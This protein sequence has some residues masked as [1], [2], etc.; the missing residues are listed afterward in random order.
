MASFTN[1]WAKNIL[2]EECS[3][4]RFESFCCALFSEVDKCSYVTTSWNYDQGR[5]GRGAELSKGDSVLCVSLRTDPLKKA[6]EDAAKLAAKPFPPKNIRVCI[7]QENSKDATEA[8]LSKIKQI[9]TETVSAADNIYVDGIVQI[10]ELS[11]KYPSVFEKHY[12]GE[13]ENLKRVLRSDSSGSET[14]VTGMRIAL[15][16]QFSDDAVELRCDMLRN[17]ILSALNG[18]SLNLSQ[19]CKNLSDSLKLPSVMIA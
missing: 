8:L 9:F 15:T 1:I 6:N 2:I 4:G 17:I 7:L 13:L 16:T 18:G 10:S 19:L 12:Y 14:I 3:S 11:V 5:D